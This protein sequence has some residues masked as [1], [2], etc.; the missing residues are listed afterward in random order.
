MEENK[1]QNRSTQKP[2]QHSV[3][4]QTVLQATPLN[5]LTNLYDFHPKRHHKTPANKQVLLFLT[6]TFK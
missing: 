5:F 1:K 2:A 6:D 3:L 4:K